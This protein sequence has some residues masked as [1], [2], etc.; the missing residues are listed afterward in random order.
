MNGQ[1]S[2]RI[3]V[4]MLFLACATNR[5]ASQ[6][7]QAQP[8]KAPDI[9]EEVRQRQRA[10]DLKVS[11]RTLARLVVAV[12]LFPVAPQT[13]RKLLKNVEQ[14]VLF[15]VDISSSCRSRLLGHLDPLMIL[16]GVPGC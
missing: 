15:D 3:A 8:R 16:F 7:P 14:E 10:A 1:F 6:E 9:L 11:C 13:A 2:M 4:A 12:K 5:S